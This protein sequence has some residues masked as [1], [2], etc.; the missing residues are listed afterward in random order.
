MQGE[1]KTKKRGRGEKEEKDSQ[2]REAR[3]AT[4]LQSAEGRA[5]RAGLAPGIGAGRAAPS[6]AGT[7]SGGERRHRGDAGGLSGPTWLPPSRF[8]SLTHPLHGFQDQSQFIAGHLRA[9]CGGRSGDTAGQEVGRR[10]RRR[11]RRLGRLEEEGASPA[12]LAAA[13]ARAAPRLHRH[14]GGRAG[15]AA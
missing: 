7:C 1:R 6:P 8:P 5:G 11:C 3:C 4:P 2:E 15:C 14:P 13:P 9:D 12:V 10:G